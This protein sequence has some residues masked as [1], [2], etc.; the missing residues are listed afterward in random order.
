M[1]EGPFKELV[2]KKHPIL[3]IR[4]VGTEKNLFLCVRTFLLN[5]KYSQ[6]QGERDRKE[7]DTE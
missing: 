4:L 7:I 3:S 5:E 6:K 1:S 2:I